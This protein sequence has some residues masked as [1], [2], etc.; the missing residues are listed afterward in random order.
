MLG[1]KNIH[2][3]GVNKDKI[4]IISINAQESLD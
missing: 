2:A 3:F 4:V 1:V